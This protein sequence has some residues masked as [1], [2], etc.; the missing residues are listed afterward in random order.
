MLN[1]GLVYVYDI[2]GIG[3]EKW[4]IFLERCFVDGIFMIKDQDVFWN[5]K[6]LVINEG[7]LVGSFLG[8][9]L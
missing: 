8:V 4:L 6:S 7:L 3:F 2:E 9:V 1:G 5:V